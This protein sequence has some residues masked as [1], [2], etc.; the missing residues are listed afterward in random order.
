MPTEAGS[1]GASAMRPAANDY[2]PARVVAGVTFLLIGLS[3][4]LESYHV[5][6]VQPVDVWRIPMPERE[7]ELPL[8]FVE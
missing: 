3:F 8:S 6:H 7:E 1:T 2:H 4:L 5:W